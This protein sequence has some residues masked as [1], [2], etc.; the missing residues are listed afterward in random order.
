MSL[1]ETRKR[2]DAID[3][4][5]VALLDARAEAGRK[6]AEHKILTGQPLRNPAR[7]EEVIARA[8]SLSNGSM[9]GRAVEKIYRTIIAETLAQEPGHCAGHGANNA[10]KQDVPAEIIDNIPV[11]PGFYR[12]RIYAPT[13]AHAFVPGQ[14]FQLRLPAGADGLFLRRPFAP[15][16]YTGDGFEFVYRV[17]GEGTQAMAKLTGGSQVHVLAPLG[18]AYT[19]PKSGSNALLIGGGCGAPSLA[20][21]A[22]ALKQSGVTVTVVVGAR[23]SEML[24]EHETFAKAADRVILATDDGS[25]GCK[26][27]VVDAY[28]L[29]KVA[30]PDSIYAC[31]PIPMLKA[32]AGLA[33]KLNVLC[34]VSLEERMACGFGVCMGCAVPVLDGK[35][36]GSTVFRRVCHEGPVLDSQVLAW[37]AM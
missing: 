1:D 8:V 16:A 37:N 5:I 35:A 26:G 7:E 14:F 2:I 34:Q 36:P 3:A 20:P 32:A 19:L 15:S 12:M 18:N 22:L 29:E 13:L 10:G 23:T 21:L 6:A 27:T 24:M 17:V 4:E 33:E 31:G 30:Q 11:A 25:R 28:S 9:P